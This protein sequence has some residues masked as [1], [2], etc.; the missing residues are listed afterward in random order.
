[1][2]SRR[3][4]PRGAIRSRIAVAVASATSKGTPRRTSDCTRIPRMNGRGP[5]GPTT[6]SATSSK[7][8]RRYQTASWPASRRSATP[9]RTPALRDAEVRRAEAQQRHLETDEAGD[10]HVRAAG[11]EPRQ[12]LARLDAQRG[13]PLDPVREP[14]DARAR[15]LRPAPDRRDRARARAPRAWSRCRRPRPPR[16]PPGDRPGARERAARP[17]APRARAARPGPRAGSDGA[18]DALPSTARCRAAATGRGSGRARVARQATSVLP[19]PTSITAIAVAPLSDTE[20][21]RLERELG[22]FVARE[23]ARGVHGARAHQPGEELGAVARAA[24][25]LGADRDQPL[26]PVRA[27]LRGE[28]GDR[29][30]ACARSPRARARRARTRPAR[31]V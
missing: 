23:Q 16:R 7:G 10:D 15:A 6:T 14:T 13:Q 27:R 31:A 26:D 24:Q 29:G 2:S 21:R 30:A 5:S 18:A 4:L 11:L 25:R 1:M 3:T 20:P 8:S 19:P 9:C 12:A 28:L 17:P 22:L